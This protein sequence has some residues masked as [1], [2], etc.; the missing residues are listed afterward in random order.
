M[1]KYENLRL[2]EPNVIPT[3]EVLEKVLGDSF[4]AY[5]TFLDELS[6]FEIEQD[7][8][9]YNCGCK[10]WMA[11]GQYRWVTKRGTD[12]EK[13]IYWL[14]IWDGYFRVVIWFLEKNRLEILKSNVTEK[15]KE[16]IRGAK[17]FGKLM[18]FP[19]EFDI[20][21]VSPLGDIYTLIGFKKQLEAA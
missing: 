13:T 21:S 19:L 5:E 6:S 7:W 20:T 18:T 9:Y 3:F 10:S 12:K 1:S 15:T 16:I 14:S 8:Q 4:I 2:K 11:K 17:T